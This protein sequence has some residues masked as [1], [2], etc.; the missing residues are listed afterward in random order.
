MPSG[1]PVS[2][3]SSNTS[4]RSLASSRS[5]RSQTSLVGAANDFDLDELSADQDVML[6]DGLGLGSATASARSTRSAARGG[7]A[8]GRGGRA[9][10]ASKRKD[11]QAEADSEHRKTFTPA[12]IVSTY[13]IELRVSILFSFHYSVIYL[14]F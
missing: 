12:E 2:R 5:T 7:S 6:T 11:A 13:Y 1:A 3:A 14:G 4:Y 9:G 8:K 10:S